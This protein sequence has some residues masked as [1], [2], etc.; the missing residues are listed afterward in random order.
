MLG[1]GDYYIINDILV[2]LSLIIVG[3]LSDFAFNNLNQN[4]NISLAIKD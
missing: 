1:I 2:S 4:Q 3:I